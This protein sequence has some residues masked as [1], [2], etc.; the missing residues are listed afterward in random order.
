MAHIT[1]YNFQV[2]ENLRKM[3]EIYEGPTISYS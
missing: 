1:P 3:G 2:I